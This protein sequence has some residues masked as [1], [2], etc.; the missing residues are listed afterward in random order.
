MIPDS[1]RARRLRFLERALDHYADPERALALAERMEWFVT[2][3]SVPVLSLPAP[4]KQGIDF[5]RDGGSGNPLAPE[6]DTAEATEPAK[7]ITENIPAA[8]IADEAED[9]CDVAVKPD[10]PLAEL[11]RRAAGSVSDE[12]EA[13]V[14]SAR[15]VQRQ[16]YRTLEKGLEA[17]NAAELAEKA[18][19]PKPRPWAEDDPKL[20]AMVAAGKPDKEIADAL[21]RSLGAV[22]MRNSELR[23]AGKLPVRGSGKVTVERPAEPASE[24]T[25]DRYRRKKRTCLKCRKPFQSLHAGNRICPRCK[26]LVDRASGI[27][28]ARTGEAL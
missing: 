22:Q 5:T 28:I 11:V 8:P 20:I 19:K 18:V 12:A 7:N 3:R 27:D 6:R 15:E 25:D 16:A 4:P 1:D 10:S 26:P 23:K 13:I 17:V 14:A 2:G 21:G 24:P 9:I